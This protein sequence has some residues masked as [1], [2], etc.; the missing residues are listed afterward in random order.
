MSDVP[1]EV[2]ERIRRPPPAGHA[3]VEGS[4]PVVSFGDYRTAKVAT[5][6][7]NQEWVTRVSRRPT[8][9]R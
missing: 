9:A 3:V 2:A 1:A 7:L 5:L 6:A 4:L 8:P